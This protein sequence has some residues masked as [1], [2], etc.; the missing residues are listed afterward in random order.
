MNT[1]EKREELSFLAGIRV[2]LSFVIILH[3][4]TGILPQSNRLVSILAATGYLYVTIFGVTIFK[5]KMN[6]R[7]ILA[8]VFILAGRR[9]VR[10]VRINAAKNTSEAVTKLYDSN[11]TGLCRVRQSPLALCV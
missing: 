9:S 7:K 6:K 8:L 5:E 3:H 4:Y 11:I 10:P 1:K 2:L